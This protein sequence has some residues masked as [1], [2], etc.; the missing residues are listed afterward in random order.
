MFKKLLVGL[1]LVCILMTCVV[2]VTAFANENGPNAVVEIMDPMVL[3]PD[4]DYMCWPSG[5]DSIDRPLQ[6]I[7]NFKAQDTY[8]EAVASEYG[9]WICD[10]YL[11][12]KGA[13]GGMF[14]T[15]GCYLAGNYGDFGWIV[16]PADALAT[17]LECDVAYPIVAAYDANLTYE[18]ICDYVKDFTAA[19]YI[20]PELIEANPEFEVTL[21]LRMTNPENADDYM[22]VG[23]PAVYDAKALMA[24]IPN[25]NV[26]TVDGV[27][28]ETIAEAFAALK[29]NSTLVILAGNHSETVKLPA[30]LSN[31]TITAEEGAILQD[32]VI[33]AADGNAYSYVDLTFDGLVFDNARLVFTGWRNGEE[34]IENLT[35]TNCVF[36]NIVDGSNN[37]AVHVNKDAAEAVNGFTFTNNVIDGVGG[38]SNSGIYLQA[39]GSILIANNVINNVAFR[40]FVV[41]V[42]TDD[43]IADDFVVTGNTFSGSASG[44]LQ[45]LGNNDAGADAVNLVINNNI[46]QGITSSQQICYWNFNSAATTT[47]FSKNYYDIDVLASA[48]RFYYNGACAD[49]ED[50]TNMG[51]FPI[52]TEL[53]AD[54]TI[55]LDSAFEPVLAVYVAEVNGVKYETVQAAINA[56]Q[57]GDTVTI[58]A[59][60]YSSINISNKNITIQGTVGANGELLT[61]IKGG[62]PAITAHGFNGTIKD[63]NIVDAWKVMYAEP[64]GNVT[65]DNVSVTGATYGFHLVAYSQGLTWTIQNS[66]MD[67]SWANSFGVYGNGDAAIVIKGNEFVSTAPYYPDY[68]ALHVNSFLP[69]V[70][71]VENIFG[72]NARIRICVNSSNIN[73]YKNY[74]ADGIENVFVDDSAVK[75]EILEYY[76]DAEMT[77][78]VKALSGNGSETDPYLIKSVDDLILFRDSVNAGETKYNAPGVYVALAADIDLAGIDWSVNIG[79]D[80]NATFDGIFDGQNHTIYNLTSTETAQKGDGYICTGLFGAIYGKAVIKNLTIENATINTG[81]FTGNNVGIL[82][83]FAYAATGSIENVTIKGDIKVDAEGAYSVGAVVGYLYCGKLAIEN[84]VVDANDGSYINAISGAGAIIGYG[85]AAQISGCSVKNIEITAKGLVGGIAGIFNPGATVSNSSVENVA[86]N[87][88]GEYWVN[89]AAIVVGTYSSNIVLNISDISFANVTANG[90]ETARLL[91]SFYTEK[92]TE[93]LPG[94]N[95]QVGNKYYAT[96]AEALAAA[97]DGETITL[98][99]AIT[100]SADETLTIDKNVIITYT[101]NVAGEDMFTVKGTL[102]INAGKIVY[103]NTDSTGSNVTVSTISCEPGSVL[104]VTGGAIENRTV[105]ANGS[106]IYSYAIDMLTNGSLGDVTVTISG[107]TV[108]SDYMAIRQFNNG[109]VCKNTLTVTDGYIYGAKRAL[110]IHIDNDAAYTTITGGKFEASDYALCFLTT[111]ENITVSGGEFIGLVWYSGED[112]FIEGGSF[113]E[114]VAEEYCAAGFIPTVNADGT[115]GVK[116]GEFVVS[117]NGVKYESLAEALAAANGGTVELLCDITECINSFD[118]VSLITNVAGGVTFTNTCTDWVSTTN[119]FVGNGVT[120]HMDNVLFDDAGVNTIEGTLIIDTT[121]YNAYDSKTT[122]QN[123]GSA[124][125]GGMIVNRYHYNTDSGIYV[126]GDGNSSTVEIKSLDTIGTYSGTFYAKDAVVEG[127]MFW[128]DYIKGSTQEADKYCQSTPV[129]ENSVLNVASELRFY[130]D[131]TLTLINS[132]VTAGKAQVRADA[133]PVVTKDAASAIKADTVENVTGALVQAVLGAD[134]TVSF[135]A[136]V[137]KVGNVTYG[138]LADAIAAVADGGTITLLGNVVIDSTT[139]VSS[140]G[141]W[142]EGVYIESDKSFTLDLGG[143]TLTQDGSVNDYLVFIKNIGSKASVI[144]FKNGTLD[145]GTSAYCALCTSSGSTQ[146]VTINLE[147]INVINNNY[148]GSTIKVRGGTV[149]NVN[150]GTKIVGKNSYLAIECIASTANIYD[151]AEIYMNGASSYNGCLVGVGSN[152]VV[153]VYG[154]YGKGVKGGFIAMTSGGTINIYGGEWIANTDGSVGDNSNLYVLTAQSNSYESGFAGGSF[155]NVYGGTLRGGMDA[156]VLNNIG[157]EQAGLL[158][159]GGNF[160]VDPTRYLAEGYSALY[161]DGVYTAVDFKSDAEN[162]TQ[163]GGDIAEDNIVVE[164]AKN[165][166]VV[167]FPEITPEEIED[168][169]IELEITVEEIVASNQ[170]APSSYSYNVAPMFGVGDKKVKIEE[171]E[172]AVTFRLPVHSSETRT[173]AKVYHYDDNGNL[174]SVEVYPIKEENGE[175]YVEVSSDSFSTFTVEPASYAVIVNGQGYET[176][177]EGVA[178][179]A[180]GG[181][182]KLVSDV[183]VDGNI[184]ISDKA[185]TIDLN[186][187]VLKADYVVLFTGSHIVDNGAVK[188][189]LELESKDKL[190]LSTISYPML[191]MWNEAETGYVFVAVTKLPVYEEAKGEDSFVIDFRPSVKQGGVDNKDV[192]GDGAADNNLEFTV[193]IERYKDGKL[194]DVETNVHIKDEVIS[195]AYAGGYYLRLSVTGASDMYDYYVV[196]LIISSSSNA[197]VKYVGEMYTF[198]P[199]A[200]EAA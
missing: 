200:N 113:S 37:A 181:T 111:S 199:A 68:G 5:D 138:T 99:K 75:P 156:W 42:T 7:M 110:Q 64:A 109:A 72:E 84:C 92:P 32:M 8:D 185:V 105:K 2:T 190:V 9:K 166:L 188:G 50:L 30:Y 120:L 196:K 112:G 126:Y 91:G 86:L 198:T 197:S 78:L 121:L 116:A 163:L 161:S 46:F 90:A 3:T 21:E 38:S 43:G 155:I 19:I 176:W 95:L 25:N 40:P 55:N 148:N 165:E 56:A 98:L 186:G 97:Q 80:C 41:Q 103:V 118:N 66:Y 114:A 168:A 182:I 12:F 11:T 123:G 128:I 173:S 130:K 184:I 82:V 58:F 34:I 125:I 122:F 60:E 94:I 96:L 59:G 119:I 104:N 177:A 26:A 133:T 100:V 179:V 170:G 53:N 127:N 129:F 102:N 31:V 145:A 79:D 172:K 20:S 117:V 51:I 28:Y 157:G 57:N 195:Q 144:T 73:I 6:V 147:N 16:I 187:Y 76:K 83:G 134:G 10:F 1:M 167:A 137:A 48:S 27:G 135:R 87:T 4:D 14:S 71:V 88:T 150:A 154:G 13:E 54:G 183:T 140:G 193:M 29:D 23:E 47:D 174:I 191:P 189:L 93:V 153:N 74:H 67:L 175:K 159:S 18:N 35:I 164:D 85:D 81:A 151:G 142:Y 106:S 108:Y 61:T 45:G 115:Y 143:Y 169:T 139:R 62:D 52:Y 192:F 22:V 17:E 180:N 124:E 39:T 141:G 65:I 101:S 89:S 136:M 152:G 149:L 162:N 146:Q 49:V 194:D 70:T 36:K 160:N 24:G 63:I 77:E 178:A 107:G 69:N 158:I 33:S 132:Q 44:R 131:A 171:L 15:E